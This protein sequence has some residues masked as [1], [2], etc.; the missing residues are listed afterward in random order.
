[1]SWK[2]IDLESVRRRELGR[3]PALFL[4]LLV[5]CALSAT[6]LQAAGPQPAPKASVPFDIY[7]A[8]FIELEVLAA[9]QPTAAQMKRLAEA[10]YNTDIDL[11]RP[12]EERGFEEPQV[13]KQEGLTYVNIPVSLE[14]LDRATIERFIRVFADAKRPVVVHCA[15]SNRVGALYYAY[16]VEHK[17]MAP[18][19]AMPLALKAGLHEPKL[20]EKV[21]SLVASAE[22]HKP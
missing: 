20:I 11:R 5:I 1:M 13:A 3:V 14:L 7:H 10:G 22:S 8:K 19:K 2:K 9:G 6:M 21:Q 16:L 17:G 15:S 4:V 18:A 12:S